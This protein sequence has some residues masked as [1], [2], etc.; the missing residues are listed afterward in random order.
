MR[1][2]DVKGG[3][4]GK[5]TAHHYCGS[6]ARGRSVWACICECGRA[7]DVTGTALRTGRVTSCGC[8][9]HENR[10]APRR[11]HGGSKDLAYASWVAML[12]RCE[13]PQRTK[14]DCHGG[15]G[16]KVC[17]RWHKYENFLKDMGPRESTAFSIERRNNNGDYKPSNCYW[18][19]RKEQCR[20]RRNN[21]W[22]QYAGKKQ[23]LTE[24]ALEVGLTQST[25][26]W[27][28]QQGWSDIEI[29]NGR[30]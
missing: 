18:A 9:T 19:T 20:N 16:I 1:I 15:R 17:K 2:V 27:R 5:L 25:L 8:M 4:F 13:N 3:V 26:N 22:L 6:N 24:W 7:R 28:R 21:V 14:F 30:N 12:H 10:S 11:T 29:I 23:T